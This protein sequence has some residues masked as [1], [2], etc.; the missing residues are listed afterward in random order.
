MDNINTKIY[1][2]NTI[3]INGISFITLDHAYQYMMSILDQ[4]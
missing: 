4:T 2:K 1:I 3:W